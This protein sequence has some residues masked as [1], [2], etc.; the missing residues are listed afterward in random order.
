MVVSTSGGITLSRKG[1][2]NAATHREIEDAYR[3]GLAV[4]GRVV[5]EVKGGYEV[6]IA[7]E[8][9][10]WDDYMD[11]YEDAITH[12]STAY[13]PWHV[14]PAD[15][16]WFTRLAVSTVVVDALERLDLSCDDGT[17]ASRDRAAA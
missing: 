12:T 7:R 16:K 8:R 10:F 13:A 17:V 1:V 2:R 11:A 14:I 3:N 5:Q 9:A 4:E 15:N 6:R